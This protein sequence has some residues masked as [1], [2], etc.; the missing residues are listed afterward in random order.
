MWTDLDNEPPRIVDPVGHATDQP[1]ISSVG[2]VHAQD[3]SHI[4]TFHCLPAAQ[5]TTYA[6]CCAHEAVARWHPIDSSVMHTSSTRLKTTFMLHR[7]MPAVR[8]GCH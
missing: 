5:L 1:R 4:S 8:V 7:I 6:G 3:L 2:V